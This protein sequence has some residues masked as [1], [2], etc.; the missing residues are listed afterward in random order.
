MS[1]ECV[2]GQRLYFKFVRNKNAQIFH[3][4]LTLFWQY[5]CQNICD[6]FFLNRMCFNVCFL[7]LLFFFLFFLFFFFLFLFF[8]FSVFFFLFFFLQWTPT[9]IYLYLVWVINWQPV[10]LQYCWHAV[11]LD[12]Q[13]LD[14]GVLRKK[15]YPLFL[16]CT[17][18]MNNC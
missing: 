18:D 14:T 7:L 2:S 8:F 17:F 3:I 5:T 16:E 11:N 1:D 10:W 9:V 15:D 12:K 13:T 6:S 4:G